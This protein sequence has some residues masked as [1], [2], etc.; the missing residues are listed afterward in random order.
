MVTTSSAISK[1]TEIRMPTNSY[2]YL[3]NKTG[4]YRQI[5]Y[6]QAGH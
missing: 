3:Y 2:T 1:P 5:R 6:V 4:L